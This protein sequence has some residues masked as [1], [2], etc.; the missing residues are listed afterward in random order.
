MREGFS[1]FSAKLYCLFFALHAVFAARGQPA[2]DDF[3]R[4]IAIP[5]TN[6]AFA[7][8]LTDATSQDGEPVIPGVSIGQSVVDLERASGRHGEDF[9][10]RAHVQPKASGGSKRLATNCG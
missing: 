1:R 4:R 6:A 10:N 7:G 3:A 8:T 9:R 2:N 5:G